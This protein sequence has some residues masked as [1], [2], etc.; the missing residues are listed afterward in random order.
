MIPLSNP[1]LQITNGKKY[2]QSLNGKLTAHSKALQSFNNSSVDVDKACKLFQEILL[3]AA[4]SSLPSSRKKRGKTVSADKKWFG[5]E[6]KT[7]KD[8]LQYSLKE[9]HRNPENVN[10]REKCKD[11]SKTYSNRCKL[12]KKSFWEN[13]ITELRTGRILG[14]T[15]NF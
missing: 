1:L 2:P 8:E 11:L 13:K 10:W 6:C 14:L 12:K 4:K 7:L 5:S 9:R 3:S 15:E